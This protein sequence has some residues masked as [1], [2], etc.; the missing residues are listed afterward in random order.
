MTPSVLAE[1]STDGLQVERTH[2]SI[3]KVPNHGSS[4]QIVCSPTHGEDQKG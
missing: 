3:A 4:K 1:G 2:A